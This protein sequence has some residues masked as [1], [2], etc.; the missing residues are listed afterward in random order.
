MTR[1]TLLLAAAAIALGAATAP[2]LAQGDSTLRIIVPYSAGGP[3]DVQ[4]RVLGER[5]EQTLKRPV[6]IE[7]RTGAGV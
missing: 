3:T 7:N 2:A 1:R 6:V 5:L 4:A